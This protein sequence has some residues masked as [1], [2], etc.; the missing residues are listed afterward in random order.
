MATICSIETETE[1]ETEAQAAT[2]AGRAGIQASE[3]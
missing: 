3:I 1:P 2:E